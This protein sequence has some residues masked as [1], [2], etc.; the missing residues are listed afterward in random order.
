MAPIATL[1]VR[2]SAQLAEFQ[3]TFA[4][5]SGTLKKFTNEFEGV[6]TRASAV[7]AFFGN[8]AA[9]IARSLAAGFGRAVSDAIRLSSEFSN[10]L[11]GLSSVSRAFGVDA[12]AAKNA[13]RG[14]SADGLMPLKDSATGLKNL[15]ATGF[16][17]DQSIKLMN[18][19]KDSAAFGRQGALSFG[20]AV[21]TATEGVK[22]GNSILVDNA[23]VTK[24]L[25]QILKEAG[26][27]AQDLSRAS[28]DAAVRMALFNGILKETRAQTG[29][30]AKLTMTYSGQVSR[31]TS[32]FEATLATIGAA[33]TQNQSV[34]L[35]I[36]A[37]GDAFASL[38]THL[39]QN[40]NAFN[41][42]S[43]AVIFIAKAM[44][45]ALHSVDLLQT[46]FAGLQ[47]AFNE[48][49]R[50]GL[51]MAHQSLSTFAILA[52][53]RSQFPLGGEEWKRNAVLA[54]AALGLI[55][56]Q[57]QGFA[58]AT[59]DAE[60]RSIRWGN[61]LQSGVANLD[62]LVQ[63]LEA[64][65]GKTVELGDATTTTTGSTNGATKAV[66]ENEKALKAQR[67]ALEETLDIWRNLGKVSTAGPGLTPLDPSRVIAPRLFDIDP[68][69]DFLGAI[70]L[71]PS[72]IDIGAWSKG[73]PDF[74]RQ[75]F[76]KGLFGSP[77]VMGQQLASTIV[78][79][80]QGGGSAAQSAIG[81][82]GS[83]V[84]GRLGESLTKQGG[85]L[86]NK[87]L[88][89]IFA[90]ALPVVGS[91]IGP[92]VGKIWGSL[93]G[94]A[95]RDTKLDMARQLFGSVEEM[96]KLMVETLNKADYDRLW[97]Q[98]SEV[99]QNNKNQAVA[100]IEAIKA[101]LDSQKAKHAEVA[102][103]A[104]A[105]A[106]AQQDA[107]DAI[108]AKY[109]T[110]IDELESE[111]KSLSDSVVKEAAEEF[112]GITE[113]RERERMRQI[114]DELAAQKAMRDAEIAAKKE[115][116]AE[117]LQAGQDLDT[118]LRDMFERG[119]KI[120]LTFDFPDGIPG[121]ISPSALSA[122]YEAGM[123]G[124]WDRRTSAA[125][126]AAGRGGTA[127]F[128]ADGRLLAE[129]IVPHIPGEVKRLGLNR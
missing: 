71:D 41:L 85:P 63:A 102:A 68:R 123:L 117:T 21:R 25:S 101:A 75:N 6:A 20:D 43:D 26:F 55:K 40:R 111:Y 126:I 33:V 39:V 106:Q 2:L 8:I 66:K 93:F 112:M 4:D 103:A 73:I 72:K 23:G 96:Q 116:F 128:L 114:E 92:L 80:F 77:A 24:N 45:M 113:M 108:A 28:S 61:T 62:A 18:A 88:G 70:G 32:A 95:G 120:P 34:A 37:V 12:D 58:D 124:E 35:A 29:D 127:Q 49:A 65:R 11:I 122:G 1:T 121:A 22:N 100:A 16:S 48:T 91:L 44:S 52:Q 67:K 115:T 99:G 60:A 10:A 31:L 38:N 83:S 69:N 87:A 3:K 42:V 7:G 27:S 57:M 59:K 119:Y 105:S 125:P 56:T 118:K 129:I 98:F 89:D 30:A 84:A 97:K 36:K 51:N 54:S 90:G 79:A 107:L 109:K 19:F 13:A 82:I 5:T 78:G 104:A 94:T 47:I 110:K 17:L 81:Q 15:L 64:S 14:L 86:F 76:W 9:D 74:Q 50:A 53:L 46:G